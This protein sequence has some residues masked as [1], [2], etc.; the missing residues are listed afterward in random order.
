MSAGAAIGGMHISI[1]PCTWNSKKAKSTK[2][3]LG[4]FHGEETAAKAVDTARIKQVRQGKLSL[5]NPTQLRMCRHEC[6]TLQSINSCC[7]QMMS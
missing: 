3:H 5:C 4:L 7:I 2:Q 1:E 6:K